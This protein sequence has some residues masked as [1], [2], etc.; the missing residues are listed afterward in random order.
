M[1]NHDLQNHSLNT[2]LSDIQL[3]EVHLVNNNSKHVHRFRV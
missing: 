2:E 3:N 1:G